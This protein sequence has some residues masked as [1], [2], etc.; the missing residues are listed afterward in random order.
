MFVRSAG[1]YAVVDVYFPLL[2]S[3]TSCSG[4]PDVRRHVNS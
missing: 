4:K 1:M 3:E 2:G